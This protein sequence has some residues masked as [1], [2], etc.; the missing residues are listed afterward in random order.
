M[1]MME[2]SFRKGLRGFRMKMLGCELNIGGGLGRNLTQ[3]ALR[4]VERCADLIGWH[5]LHFG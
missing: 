3:E 2:K 1:R 5:W 4:A